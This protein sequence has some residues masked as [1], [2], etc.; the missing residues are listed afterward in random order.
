MKRRGAVSGHEAGTIDP[1]D[2]AGASGG[3]RRILI[4][5]RGEIAVRVIRAC[6]EMGIWTVAVYSDADREALH[7]RYAREAYPI[8]P[9][10]STESYLR[11]DKILDVAEDLFARRGFAGVGMREVAD[12]VGLGKSSLFH[13][14]RG[15]TQLYFEVLARVLDRIRVRLEPALRRDA[16]PLACA[17]RTCANRPPTHAAPA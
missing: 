10:P 17:A 8:G 3:F 11:I 15:K 2:R 6:H 7:V 12:R 4:A 9:P 1:V 14:F 13:H 5:N 16:E